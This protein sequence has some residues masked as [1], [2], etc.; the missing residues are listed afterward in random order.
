MD[1]VDQED[2]Q[3]LEEEVQVVLVHYLG[4]QIHLVG[5]EKND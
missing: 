4:T 2:I 3:E 1:Q 5:N